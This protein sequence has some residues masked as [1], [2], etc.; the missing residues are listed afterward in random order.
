MGGVMGRGVVR[1]GW[2]VGTARMEVRKEV[3]RERERKGEKAGRWRM[4]R[5]DMVAERRSRREFNGGGTED[6]AD[7]GGVK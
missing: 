7:G 1:A 4:D 2:V 5:Q 3:K 6:K